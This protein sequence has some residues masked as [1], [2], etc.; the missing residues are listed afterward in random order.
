M[1]RKKK[2]NKQNKEAAIELSMGTIVIL[3][4][5]MVVLIGGIVVVRNIFNTADQAIGD[6]DQGVK[7]AI[8]DAFS[9]PDKKIVVYPSEREIE[10]K[11]RTQG[12]GFAFSVRNVEIEDL[13]FI[14]NIY[15]DPSFDIKTK[16]QISSQEAESWLLSETG[17]ISIPRGT[18]M[19][20][21]ELIKFNIPDSAPPCTMIYKLDVKKKGG[22]LYVST[23]VFLTIKAR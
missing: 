17:S 10:I 3:V 14:Y 11:T 20:E 1:V 4:L 22:G 2:V 16:C 9:D 19:E 23:K 6:I 12:E 5:A 8:K 13:D 15:I 7:K 21:P 18:I